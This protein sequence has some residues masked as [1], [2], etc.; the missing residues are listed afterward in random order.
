MSDCKRVIARLDVKNNFLIKGVQLE[1]LRKLG[2]PHSF[3]QKYY[4]EGIDELVYIDSVAS[5]YNRNS[6]TEIIK[7]T[8]KK[9]FIPITV[10]GGIRTVEDAK[11][12]LRSGADK[13]AIN[14]AA[15]KSPKLITELANIYGTQCVV[16]NVEAKRSMTGNGWEAYYNNG[17]DHSGMTVKEWVKIGQEAGAGE[18]L[19]T[20]VD[21]DGTYKGLDIEL[22]SEITNGI[23]IPVIASGGLGK[24]QDF[25]DAIKKGNCD[26]VAVGAAL[27]YN[28]VTVQGL[29]KHLQENQIR[30]RS[31]N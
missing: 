17:R 24:E 10:G 29:K 31:T 13:I 25:V 19:L 2:D 6:L 21:R 3:S 16:L 15:I 23:R 12:I 14:T 9:I 5:L 1:G 11:T 27:H 18:I 7:N 28:K 20:S 4:T 8:S 30:V 26:A 22:I